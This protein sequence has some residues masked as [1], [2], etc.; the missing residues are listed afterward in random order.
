MVRRKYVSKIV[1][2]AVPVI[3]PLPPMLQQRSGVAPGLLAQ[4]VVSKYVHHLPLYRQ[5]QI[6][7]TQNGFGYRD[8][9]LA[10]LMELAADWLK[11]IYQRIRTGVIGGAMSKSLKRRCATSCRAT[12]KPK[13]ATF[14]RPR[15]PRGDVVYHWEISRAAACLDDVLLDDFKGTV[16]TIAIPAT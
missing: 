15:V 4:V 14:G 9:N 5:E 2:D 1:V 11:P 8:K 12:A 10:H 7:W 13:P 6:Y 3:S 16:N